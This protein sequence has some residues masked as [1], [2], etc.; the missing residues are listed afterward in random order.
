VRHGQYR[1]WV[2]IVVTGYG[3]TYDLILQAVINRLPRGEE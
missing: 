1:K 3:G 2:Y